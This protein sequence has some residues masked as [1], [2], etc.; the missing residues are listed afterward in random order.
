MILEILP[1]VLKEKFYV[2]VS[3]TK[4]KIIFYEVGQLVMEPSPYYIQ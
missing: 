3:F 2:G 4:F 1:F